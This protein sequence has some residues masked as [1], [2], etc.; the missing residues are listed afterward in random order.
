MSAQEK[1]AEQEFQRLHEMET[2]GL[3]E[4]LHKV[5]AVVEI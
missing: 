2:K 3:I 1:Q 4:A 5:Q